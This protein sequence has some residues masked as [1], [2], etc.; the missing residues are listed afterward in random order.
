M[1]ALRRERVDEW[2]SKPGREGWHWLEQLQDQSMVIAYWRPHRLNWW[3]ADEEGR[4]RPMAICG[5]RRPIR[6]A[7]PSSRRGHE[8]QSRTLEERLKRQQQALQDDGPAA[9]AFRRARIADRVAA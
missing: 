9:E 4:T 6:I 2:S 5:S 7:L 3:V 1:V 8:R